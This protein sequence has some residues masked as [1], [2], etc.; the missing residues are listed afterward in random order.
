MRLVT[1][2]SLIGV[3][4]LLGGLHREASRLPQLMPI[5]EAVY[6][7]IRNTH[8][9]YLMK[10]VLFSQSVIIVVLTLLHS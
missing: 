2:N 7:S 10:Q 4:A 6:V 3:V 1:G 5:S 8:L 9:G